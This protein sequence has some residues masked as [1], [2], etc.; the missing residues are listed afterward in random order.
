MLPVVISLKQIAKLLVCAVFAL[1]ASTAAASSAADRSDGMSE[2]RKPKAL[3][4]KH[5]DQLMPL[6]ETGYSGT[7]EILL[8]VSV[9][10]RL[11]SGAAPDAESGRLHLDYQGVKLNFLTENIAGIPYV[12]VA[13]L[14]PVLGLNWQEDSLHSLILAK[15]PVK[16]AKKSI[17]QFYA[18]EMWRPANK[19]NLVWDHIWQRTPSASREEPIQGLDVLSPTWFAVTDESGYV[20]NL[21][22]T[23][24]V[25]AAHAKG[26]KVWALVTN[27]FD[28]DLTHKILSSDKAQE[29]I[30]RQLALYADLYRLD[31][32]NID[33]EN[34]YDYDKDKFSAFVEKLA[35]TLRQRNLVVSI[36]L[37]VPSGAPN[38]SQCYDRSRLG[39]AV[40][41]VMV[42]TYDEHW[43]KSP[44]SGSVASLPWVEKG[45][46]NTLALIPNE[47]ILLGLPFYTREWEESID[48][49]GKKTVTAKTMSMAAVQKTIDAYNLQ[50]AWLADIGQHYVEYQK[51]GKTY[52]IW[53]E[54]AQSLRLKIGLV[55][56]Y[57]LAG[58][59]SWRKGF[60]AKHIWNTL[61]TTLRPE[62]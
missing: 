28:P 54:D 40:D 20:R 21:A 34:I 47:K 24:Y 9:V 49:A 23:A 18:R 38:W 17:P 59:A 51:N 11:A 42:M 62:Y 32:I 43:R 25:Q 61:N 26:Y 44:V 2:A 60:E 39:A 58:I 27:S 15:Q 46:A 52:K 1:S 19:I 22:D 29:N 10:A 35:K 4:V 55:H 56:K 36:D 33:F 48:E 50:P 57:H 45:I 53:I 6:P 37:T 13:N 30:I 8:P 12:N 31:G 41:Y 16:E 14:E 7:G 5:Q 3:T